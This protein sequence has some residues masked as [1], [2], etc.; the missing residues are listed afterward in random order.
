MLKFKWFAIGIFL[1]LNGWVLASCNAQINRECPFCCDL[2]Y[3]WLANK[4]LLYVWSYLLKWHF[5]RC[6]RHVLPHHST[7]I[8]SFEWSVCVRVCVCTVHEKTLYTAY[9][10]ALS[11]CCFRMRGSEM[12]NCWFSLRYVVPHTHTP[13]TR[14][15]VV[16]KNEKKSSLS[17]HAHSHAHTAKFM[18]NALVARKQIYI[19]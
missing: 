7:N 9:I 10:Q 16:R 3:D 5:C 15:H 17:L 2:N 14:S 8:P 4:C 11:A 6:G 18:V 13:Y 12:M 19:Y 1:L